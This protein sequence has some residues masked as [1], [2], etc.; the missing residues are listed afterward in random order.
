MKVIQFTGV[1]R[2]VGVTT[3]A[4]NL[5]LVLAWDLFDHR[6]LLVDASLANPATARAFGGSQEPGLLNYLTNDVD[7]QQVVQPTIRPNLEVIGTGRATIQVLSPFNL[8]KFD[9]FL[10][11]ARNRYDYVVMD[12]API[13]RSSD[14]FIISGKVDGVIL[15]AKAN[16]SRYEVI[17]DI[18]SR[19]QKEAKLT[20]IVLN[21][22]RFVI[23]KIL[24][25]YV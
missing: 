18:E 12:T 8:L 17:N 19:L 21:R 7:L 24:Y 10:E 14:S 11:E 22:R 15:V 5:A 2:E 9:T 16:H 3:V 4:S 13:L 6:I 25:K 20:G 1:D 23:P